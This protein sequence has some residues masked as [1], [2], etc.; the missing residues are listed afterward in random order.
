MTK[1]KTGGRVTPKGTQPTEQKGKAKPG[2]PV[3]GAPRALPGRVAPT[4]GRA[5][6]GN[7][8]KSARSGHH[9]GNR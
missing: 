3:A 8:G 4:Q 7:V 9:G 6:F 5:A 1:K 2:A